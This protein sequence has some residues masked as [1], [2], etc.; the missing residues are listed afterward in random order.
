M[1]SSSGEVA[2]Y[3][4]LLANGVD[5]VEE[6]EFDDL[7]TKDGRHLRFDFAVF[8]ENDNVDFVIEFN[9]AQHYR[10]IN[11]FGGMANFKKQRYN[12]NEKRK[13]CLRKKIPLVEIPYYDEPKITYDYILRKAG[14]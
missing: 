10:P 5:F 13:Y 8:D 7:V 14:Y 9:G 2:V 4:T 1:R 6:Y 3:N 11:A 12:D